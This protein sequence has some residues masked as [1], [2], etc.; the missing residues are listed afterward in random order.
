MVGILIWKFKIFIVVNEEGKLYDVMR[1]LE[2]LKLILNIF[3]FV[4][5]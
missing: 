5:I 4:V 2:K 1:M 3:F